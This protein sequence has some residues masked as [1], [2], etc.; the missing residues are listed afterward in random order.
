MLTLPPAVLAGAGRRRMLGRCAAGGGRRGGAAGAGWCAVLAAGRRVLVQRVRADR[1]DGVRDACGGRWRRVPGVV[2]IGRPVANTRVFVLD[3]WLA[4]VPA[5]GGGGA[6]RGRGGAGAGVPG[7]GRAD[8][9]A[10]RGV[11]VRGAGERMYRTGDLARWT[12][13]GELVFAGRADE[14]VKIRGFRVE[15]GEVEAVL[16]ARPGV[17]QA[18]VV[19]PRGRPGRQAAG[20]LR[21]PGR[22]HA[23]G[24]RPARGARARGRAA[25]GVH[26]AR[27]RSWCW[28]RC[29]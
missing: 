6:V 16:A 20:R 24:W 10:V 26:G 8:R 2:P 28:T 27:R 21:R 19:G 22:R 12:P 1:G 15:P 7:P 4:P 29:R 3:E 23:T 25:A 13:D 14:Q 18:A 11:P 5:G 9:G 17:A